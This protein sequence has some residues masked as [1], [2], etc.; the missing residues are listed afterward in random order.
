MAISKDI[1]T[2]SLNE[3]NIWAESLGLSGGNS[4]QSIKN[5]L[6]QYYKLKPEVSKKSTDQKNITIT[7]AELSTYYT[8]T[9]VDE[10]VAE[11]EGRVEIIIDDPKKKI[12]HSIVADKINFN[13]TLDSVTALGNVE[14]IKTEKG[15]PE[16]VTAESMTFSLDNWQ[17]SLLQCVSKQDKEIKKEK[18]IFYYVTGELKKS[19]TEVMGME[20]VTIQ[21]VSGSPLFNIHASELW[22]LDSSE[23]LI[24][25]PI[26]KVGNVPVFIFPFYYHTENSLY[27]NPSYG[28]RSREGMTVQNTIYLMGEKP[29][30]SADSD[31][32]FLSF[33]S[34]EVSN[35][36]KL[37]GLSLVPS[38]D[39]VSYNKNYSK[40]MIDYYSKLGLYIGNKSSFKFKPY[41]TKLELD[42]GL[43]F[44]R[45][46][47]E[48]TGQVFFDGN[49]LWNN[50]YILKN[51]VPFRY[52][53]FLVVN[54]PIFDIDFKALSDSLFKSD[55]YDREENFMWVNYFTSQL[56]GGVDALNSSAKDSFSRDLTTNSPITSYSM[57]IDFKTFSPKMEFMKPFLDNFELDSRKMSISYNRKR[58]TSIEDSWDP[59]YYFFYPDKATLPGTLKLSGRFFDTSWDWAKHEK[60]DFEKYKYIDPLFDVTNNSPTEEEKSSNDDIVSKIDIF[61]LSGIEQVKDQNSLLGKSVDIFSTSFKYSIKIPVNFN[62]SIDS[63]SW[64]TPGDIDYDFNNK[65]LL[66]NVDPSVSLGYKLNIFDS[67]L[68]V[69]NNL[70]GQQYLKSYVDESDKDDLL[71]VYKWNRSQV[72]NKLK[73]TMNPLKLLSID[74]NSKLSLSYKLNEILY[75]K[76]FNIDKYQEDIDGGLDKNLALVDSSNKYYKIEEFKWDED[77][78]NNNEISLSYGYSVDFFTT[79][80]IYNKILGPLDEKDKLSINQKIKLYDFS[81][82]GKNNFEYNKG[83]LEEEGE[84]DPWKI[85]PF[86]GSVT[87]SPVNYL[88][89]TSSVT[90]DIEEEEFTNLTS[91]FKL[92]GLNISYNS[93]FSQGESWNTDNLRWEINQDSEKELIPQ[94]IS[95]SYDLGNVKHLF[96]KNRVLL[97]GNVNIKYIKKFIRVDES[98]FNF[99]LNFKVDIYNF[100]SFSFN[101]TSINNSTYLYWKKDREVFDITDNYNI[102]EDFIKSFNIFSDSDRVESKFN[103][104]TIVI[105]GTY[106]MPDWNLLFEYSGA[107][108]LMDNLY[109]WYPKYSFFV[110]WKPLSMVRS[111]VRLEDEVWSVSTSGENN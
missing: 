70:V 46:I 36:L 55:F 94:K 22:M 29:K 67:F 77:F 81:I 57:G 107:P 64:E 20:D 6:F 63:S 78:V 50:S 54:T 56:D 15:K 23:F 89:L 51:E 106:K 37:N 5:A 71:Q 60:N 110:E 27:F 16:L 65:S 42:V 11:F 40:L 102:V 111:D 14:Y 91:G 75:K 3:L 66:R 24:I 74:L 33:D 44:S 80:I 32:S 21:T 84:D 105:K 34:G 96:W 86:S 1:E 92:K 13:R 39:K 72:N 97:E 8:V 62:W 17:G 98:T 69:D 85:Y 73:L 82:S 49:S 10:T 41:I 2:S 12:Q 68:V 19:D 25:L 43:G 108:K 53:L 31:F 47:D 83:I 59:S 35:N 87:Y 93:V 90:Y 26:I 18:M 79:S 101:S 58:N 9:E 103:L 61:E 95:L 30:N 109:R 4:V 104:N 99:N 38:Q 45:N 88:S 28:I 7:K 100:L 48:T 52:L 76:S